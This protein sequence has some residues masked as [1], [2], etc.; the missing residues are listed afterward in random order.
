MILEI[1]QQKKLVH[2]SSTQCIVRSQRV[3]G[4]AC[5][6]VMMLS[7]IFRFKIGRF[8]GH[9]NLAIDGFGI[10]VIKLVTKF[11]MTQE[12]AFFFFLS[13]LRNKSASRS[14]LE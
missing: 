7:V 8:Q 11:F 10:N 9:D 4:N 1:N 12:N 13:F 14:L 3:G 5:T 6:I 2:F